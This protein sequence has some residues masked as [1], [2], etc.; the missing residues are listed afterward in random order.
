M[1]TIHVNIDRVVLRGIDPANKQALISG[2][3]TELSRILA[4]PAARAAWPQNPTRRTPVLR[5]GKM[6]L[7]PGTAGARKLGTGIARAIGKGVTR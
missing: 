5:L 3:Q 6:P 7:A 2:L 1:S 4:D